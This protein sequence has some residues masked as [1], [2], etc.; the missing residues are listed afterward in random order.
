MISYKFVLCPRQNQNLF[1]WNE[2]GFCSSTH[3]PDTSIFSFTE[4]FTFKKMSIFF[5][6]NGIF[7]Q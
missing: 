7:N 3:K 1:F 4:K 2:V 6:F 5:V